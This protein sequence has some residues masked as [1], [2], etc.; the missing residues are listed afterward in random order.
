[1]LPGGR[2]ASPLPGGLAGGEGLGVAPPGGFGGLQQGQAKVG[3]WSVPGG[4]A[5]VL[6]SPQGQHPYG[7]GKDIDGFSCWGS[8]T[9]VQGAACSSPSSAIANV[10]QTSAL[11]GGPRKTP[12]AILSMASRT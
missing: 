8:A 6:L 12:W 2:A 3:S 5:L 9:V 7:C 1:M 11:F 10:P 4:H